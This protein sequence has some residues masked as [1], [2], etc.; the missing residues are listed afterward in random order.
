MNPKI[1]H[2]SETGMLTTQY[3]QDPRGKPLKYRHFGSDWSPRCL[4]LMC[5]S[6]CDAMLKRALKEF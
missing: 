2:I 1:Y 4:D 6:V 5:V 3:L